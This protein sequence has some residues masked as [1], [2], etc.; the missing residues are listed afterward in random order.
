MNNGFSIWAETLLSSILF[1]DK[2]WRA[3][4]YDTFYSAGAIWGSIGPQRFFGIGSIYQNL[5]W[6]FLAGILLPFVPWIGNK[7]YKSSYWHYI[8]IPL[9]A[10]GGLNPG[11][12]QVSII[13]PLF[14]GWFFQHYLFHKHQDWWKK[15]NYTFAIASDVGVGLAIL[16]IAGVQGIGL[17]S[18]VWALNPDPDSVIDYYCF[19]KPWYKT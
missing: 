5:L 4:G 6:F 16:L 11:Y 8:N 19:D 17:N 3:N 14:V 15:Y 13:A 9:L 12:Y 7:L 2:D 18:P 10:S 1:I